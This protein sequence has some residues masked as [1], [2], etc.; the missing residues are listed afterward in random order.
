MGK[1]DNRAFGHLLEVVFRGFMEIELEV[2]SRVFFIT[3][4]FK[5]RSRALNCQ[6]RLIFL[7]HECHKSCKVLSAIYHE[8]KCVLFVSS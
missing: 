8:E 2:K 6:I 1:Y 3:S 7:Q 4:F 5:L